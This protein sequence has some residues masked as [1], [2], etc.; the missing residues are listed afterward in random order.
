MAAVQAR[1]RN[2]SES[3]EFSRIVAFTDGIFAIAITLLV[4]NFDVPETP[5]AAPAQVDHYVEALTGDLL[6][7]FLTFAVVGRLWLVHHRLFSTLERFDSRLVVL[8]LAYLSMIVLIPFPAE[9][10]GDYGDQ[11]LPVVIY[12]AV[13]GAAASLNLIMTH[14]AVTAGLVAAE[15]REATARGWSFLFIPVIF[16]LSIPVALASPLAAELMWTALILA[17]IARGLV[18][19]RKRLG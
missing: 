10:L 2:T 1:A 7:Y 5:S 13:L 3:V 11:R 15:H 14:H 4:L 6:A 8:N 16:L 18:D 17:R 12:A 19:R 9:L